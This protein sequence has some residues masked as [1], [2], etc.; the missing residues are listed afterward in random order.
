MENENYYE[1]LGV[2]NKAT[3]DEITLAKNKLAKKYHPDVNMRHGIDTTE[4]MQAIL[5]AYR[6]LSDPDSRKEY[7][8]TI[9]G[10]YK[11]MQTFDL[12]E[13]DET[14]DEDS[15]LVFYWK[16]AGA[17]HEIVTKSETIFKEHK[18]YGKL[19]LLSRRAVKHILILRASMIP[20]RYWHPDIMNWLLF[21]WYQNRN[22]TISYLLTLYDNHV[23]EDM[24]AVQ[25]LK[26]EKKIYLYQHSL[27]KLMKY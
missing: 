9:A 23:K 11:K 1:I 15:G 27:K 21:T 7:D 13:M 10:T 14:V 6:I 26:T 12:S 2:S 20:E 17:L 24:T 5:E 4:Q 25:R 16:T 22:Y 18:R 19:A 3:L 8:Q